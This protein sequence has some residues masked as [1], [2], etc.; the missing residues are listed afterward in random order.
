MFREG[1]Q[2]KKNTSSYEQICYFFNRNFMKNRSNIDQKSG[3]TGVRNKNRQKCCPWGSL[4]G[5]ESIFGRFLDSGGNPKIVQNLRGV[6][7]K[8]V[9]GAIWK[10]LCVFERLFLDFG[11]ILGPFWAPP[12]PILGQ[13]GVYR[14]HHHHHRRH[15][16]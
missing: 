13:F 14:H 16:H 6:L 12:K 15:H 7:G 5:I 11:S 10:P 4:F 2:V 1:R 8:G 9:S 3:K